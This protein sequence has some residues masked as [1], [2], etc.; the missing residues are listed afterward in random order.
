MYVPL[1]KAIFLHVCMYV[2]HEFVVR[3][4]VLGFTQKINREPDGGERQF[5]DS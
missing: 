2:L 1:S 4:K 5:S 3:A